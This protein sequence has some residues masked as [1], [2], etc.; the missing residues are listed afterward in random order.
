MGLG[1]WPMN[2][3]KAVEI[4]YVLQAVMAWQVSPVQNSEMVLYCRL[5]RLKNVVAVGKTRE[6]VHSMLFSAW[7]LLRRNKIIERT[8]QYTRM[9]WMNDWNTGRTLKWT[10]GVVSC[11]PIDDEWD[12]HIH[13]LIHQLTTSILSLR[14]ENWK[15]GGG[16]SFGKHWSCRSSHLK[17]KQVFLLQ[18]KL[19]HSL[20]RCQ[21]KPSAN[22]GSKRNLSLCHKH[23]FC[24]LDVCRL[25]RSFWCGDIP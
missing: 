22:P 11:S 19:L 10:T 13:T 18:V 7:R 21:S 8:L 4:T 16:C 25:V 23:L 1:R 14:K 24:M 9:M 15:M 6:R 17:L 3:P 20:L 2:K 5:I 12:S